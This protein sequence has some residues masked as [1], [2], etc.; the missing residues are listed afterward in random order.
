MS[1]A[2]IQ[3]FPL[4]ASLGLPA[5]ALFLALACHSN[6]QERDQ[7]LAPVSEQEAVGQEAAKAGQPV[8]Q[9]VGAEAYRAHKARLEKRL[10]GLG[11]SIV[12]EPPFIVI[13]DESPQTVARRSK[14]TVRWAVDLLKR[15]FFAKDPPEILEIWLFKNRKSYVSNAEKIFKDKPTTPFG[16]YSPSHK[17]LIM[18]IS[19]GGGTLVH[20]IVHPYMAANFP[21]CP[22]WFNEGMGSLF[23]QCREQDGHIVGLVNWRW[24]GLRK[25]IKTA[26]TVTIKDLLHTTSDEFYGTR[27]GLHYAQAR[28]LL[29][30]LQEQGLLRKYYKSFLAHS[31][32]DPSG[33]QT[34][35][36]TL[37]RKD[38]REF[39]KEWEA[40]VL[41]LP[42]D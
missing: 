2:S 21:D 29:L 19:T 12:V 7:L 25:A 36:S 41:M 33:F 27:S 40:W 13:G 35:Q 1:T 5:L 16:Y 18:N 14:A 20:E 32:R 39:Q 8:N 17:A 38:M 10:A 23:E 37:G 6:E 11:F 31:K 15:D 9:A 42:Q 34:L 30:Y 26:D 24:K 3:R 22:T 28:Y 4:P